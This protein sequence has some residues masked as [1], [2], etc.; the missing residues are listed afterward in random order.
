MQDF[1]RREETRR[2]R[3]IINMAA[4]KYKVITSK[5]QYKAYSNALE[6]LVFSGEKDRNTKNE[7]ALL[8]Y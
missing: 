8:T 4:L 7:I 3:K 5:A 1:D 6:E 2:K